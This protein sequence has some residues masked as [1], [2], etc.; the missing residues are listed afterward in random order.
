MRKIGVSIWLMSIVAI[1]M[2]V[3]TA[4]AF[5]EILDVFNTKYNTIGTK[6]DTCN[7]C[8]IS[9]RPQRSICG[10]ACHV[11]NK[12]QKEEVNSLNS[13]G[14]NVKDNL[15]ISIDQ[16]LA[17]IEGLD[18]DGDR[19]SNIDEIHNLTFPGDRKDFPKGKSGANGARPNVDMRLLEILNNI[20]I[21][22]KK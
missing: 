21:I 1:V 12:P 7:T 3:G 10:E 15:N 17:K 4:T 13:Y 8:H 20:S 11:P 2:I 19:F 5:P 16:A 9:A 18:S 6:L 14:M 22:T